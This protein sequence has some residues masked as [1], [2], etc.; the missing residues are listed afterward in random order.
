MR[1]STHPAP[2]SSSRSSRCIADTSEGNRPSFADA[3][4][5]ELAEAIYERFCEALR[6]LGLAV[7]TGVFGASMELELVNDGPVTIVLDTDPRYL[8]CPAVPMSQISPRDRDPGDMKDRLDVLGDIAVVVSLIVRQRRSVGSLNALCSVR[9][10]SDSTASSC[11]RH[12][13]HHALS[14]ASAAALVLGAL[15]SFGS[16]DPLATDPASRPSGGCRNA[17]R[18]HDQVSAGVAS[19][20]PRRDDRALQLRSDRPCSVAHIQPAQAGEHP[21]VA[22]ARRQPAG[23]RNGTSDRPVS[24]A[25][26]RS[27]QGPRPEHGHRH[28]VAES[29]CKPDLLSL[30]HH[31]SGKSKWARRRPFFVITA[32]C[33]EV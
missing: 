17:P 1:C 29:G 7:A 13:G 12:V 24:R 28:K 5:P 27:R 31:I 23:P 6:E 4:R 30:A 21:R 14:I 33:K 19:S 11:C 16:A 8:G 10:V 25:R 2:R 15:A 22:E 9:S 3:A 20:R 32:A 26:R 18:D